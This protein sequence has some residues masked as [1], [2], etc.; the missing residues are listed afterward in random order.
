MIFF[1]SPKICDNNIIIMIFTNGSEAIG[2]KFNIIT[3]LYI[4]SS[5][6]TK[7]LPWGYSLLCEVNP[8]N[9]N[10]STL[11]KILSCSLRP[12]GEKQ[13]EMKMIKS[14]CLLQWVFPI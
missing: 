2:V 13:R 11:Y 12:W 3:M 7:M 8:F 14:Q 1:T 5:D 9:K 4:L 10:L 6:A